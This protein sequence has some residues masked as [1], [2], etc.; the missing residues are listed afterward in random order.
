MSRDWWGP[1]PDEDQQAVLDL[2]DDL[3]ESRVH[4][5]GDDRPDAVDAAR[6]VL[7]DHGLW[8]LGAAEAGGGGGADLT[9]T[10]VA[11]ARLGG[12]WPALAWAS[13]QAHAAAL[14]LDAAG[15]P[16]AELL[17]EVHQ[18]TPVVVCALDADDAVSLTEGRL[19]GSLERIDPAGRAPH[20]VLLL[21]GGPAAVLTPDEVT[22]GPAVRRTGLD[23]ALTVGCRLDVPVGPRTLVRGPAV[24][25]ARALLH[26]GAAAVAAGIAEAA[27]Q[28]ALAYSRTRVQFGAPLTELPTVRSSLLT[29]A[30]SARTLLAAAVRA[31]TDRPEA[32]AAALAPALDVSIDVAAAAVQSH[33]GYGY[34][35]EYP[36]EGLLRDAVSLRAAARATEAAGAAARALV[37]TPG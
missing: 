33:G 14:V 6:Q 2:V 1:R 10:L 21:D 34:M 35:A 11:L 20:L 31:G 29:Q 24:D 27:A 4:R 26:V 8:T 18:G 23:G 32:A 17:R 16:W 7:A 36:V 30:A 28:A 9:T 12:T 5:T 25:H 3:V 13:V 15:D 22:F 37:W 19:T